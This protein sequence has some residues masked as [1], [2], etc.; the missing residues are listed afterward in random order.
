VVLMAGAALAAGL[1][2]SVFYVWGHTQIV[3]LGYQTESARLRLHELEETTRALKLERA[4]L[5]ALRRIAPKAQRMG[6]VAAPPERIV[7]VG[8]ADREPLP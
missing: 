2:P 3:T 1:I 5:Q 8:A 4:R 7:I 6:L